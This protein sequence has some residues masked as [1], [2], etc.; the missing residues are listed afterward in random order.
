MKRID[1]IQTKDYIAN[2]IRSE[3]LSGGIKPQE[4]LT[5]EGI[6]AMLGV[7]RMPVREALQ[8]L[9]QEGFLERL[10]NRHVQVVLLNKSQIKMTFRMIAVIETEIIEVL[11]ERESSF[12]TLGAIMKKIE[13][14]KDK[15]DK[16]VGELELLFHKTIADMADNQYI[17]QYYDKMLDGYVSYTIRNLCNTISKDNRKYSNSLSSSGAI[18]DKELAAVDSISILKKVFAAIKTGRIENIREQLLNYYGEL[19][20]VLLAHWEVKANAQ[21]GEN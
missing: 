5:Q 9:C 6:A 11:L 15:I 19:A 1:T 13:S 2:A 7:S 17:K 8:S 4:E 21:S 16:E 18:K 20:N 14:Y 3:I 12:K 10:P